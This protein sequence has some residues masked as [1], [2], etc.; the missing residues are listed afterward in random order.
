MGCPC[1]AQHHSKHIIFSSEK[2]YIGLFLY[3]KAD[4]KEYAL[5][6][7]NSSSS[8]C[9][10]LWIS[11]KMQI[12]ASKVSS[13]LCTCFWAHALCMLHRNKP[14]SNYGSIIL[15]GLWASIGV[16]HSYTLAADCYALLYQTIPGKNLIILFLDNNWN[17]NRISFDYDDSYNSLQ[18]VSPPQWAF[19][20]IL[21]PNTQH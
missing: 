11:F 12:L 5:R 18:K 13:L 14:F 15:T 7:S 1:L 16:T 4:K 3:K 10:S 9:Y 2:F 21:A 19:S 6:F 17:S 8:K 20:L